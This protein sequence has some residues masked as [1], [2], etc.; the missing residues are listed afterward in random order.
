MY[1]ASSALPACIGV[2]FSLISVFS[3]DPPRSAEEP[4]T[5]PFCKLIRNAECYDKR[6]VRTRAILA[7][8]PESVDLYDPSCQCRERSVWFEYEAP[9]EQSTRKKIRKKLKKLLDR[10]RRALVTVV[11]RFDGPQKLVL[12]EGQD[13]KKAEFLW[14]ANLGYGHLNSYRFQLVPISIEGVE[15]VPTH[16]PW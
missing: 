13:R 12:R 4:Q 8:G 11:G 15:A 10:D 16:T 6:I 1:R 7:T 14:R 3:D 5:V 9:Y 2:V